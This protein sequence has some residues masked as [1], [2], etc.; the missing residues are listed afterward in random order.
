MYKMNYIKSFI[1]IFDFNIYEVY[2]YTFTKAK[3]KNKNVQANKVR[4]FVGLNENY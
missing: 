2:C 3:N 4:V 1:S